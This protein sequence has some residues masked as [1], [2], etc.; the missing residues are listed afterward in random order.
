[1]APLALVVA[2]PQQDTEDGF[3]QPRRQDRPQTH[4]RSSRARSLSNPRYLPPA[5]RVRYSHYV[6]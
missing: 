6:L 4:P 3:S 1:M 2:E 5:L